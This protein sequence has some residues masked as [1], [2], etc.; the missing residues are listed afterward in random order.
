M[1]GLVGAPI[2]P[3]EMRAQPSSRRE[4][5]A[6]QLPASRPV[7][8]ELARTPSARI[9]GR[10]MRHL[11]LPRIPPGDLA[12]IAVPTALI[13][14]R[15]DRANRLRI[16]ET[17]SARYGWALHVIEDCADDPPRDQ[18]EAFVE[19]LHAGAGPSTRQAIAV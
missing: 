6:G 13:W 18:P 14:G 19:A 2:L 4:R 17:A 3:F 8:A 16:A 10:L 7:P 11:G 12:R 9:A 5:L 15:H 1:R